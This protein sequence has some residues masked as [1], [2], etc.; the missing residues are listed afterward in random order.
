MSLSD[1]KINNINAL[2]LVKFNNLENL[3]LS[4]NQIKNI[5]A[6]SKV[7]FNNLKI[8]DLRNNLIENINIFKKV[9]FIHLRELKLS[10]N[11]IK[12]DILEKSPFDLFKYLIIYVDR[13]Q[14]HRIQTNMRFKIDIHKI[15]CD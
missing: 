2:S 4:H 7:P 6:F 11:N 12:F 14:N 9:P 13:K 5:D 3:I 1:N 15:V 8:L 10:Y